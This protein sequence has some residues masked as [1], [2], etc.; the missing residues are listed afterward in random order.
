MLSDVKTSPTKGKS[1]EDGRWQSNWWDFHPLVEHIQRP[2]AWTTSS[3]IFVAHFTQPL[4][5]ARLL[6]SSKQF[7]IPSPAPVHSTPA[8]Y[9]PPTVISVSPNDHWLFAYFP[10]RE[11][12]GIGC[13]WNRGF[14]I[15]SW[16]VKEFWTF[17]RGA[18]V[19]AAAWA[20]AEREWVTS[21]DGSTSRL[22]HCGPLTPVTNPTLLLVT[23]AHQLNVC[24]LRTY[25]PSLRVMTC[26]L[27]QPYF[28]SE[29][30]AHPAQEMPGGA[31][32][33]R[34]CIR[35][36]IGFIYSE[37][38]ILIAMRSQRYPS[39]AMKHALDN[40]LEPVVPQG[41]SQSPTS[42]DDSPASIDWDAWGE[43]STIDLCEVKLRFDGM[44]MSLISNPLPP[45]HHTQAKLTNLLFVCTPF[46][47]DPTSS[48]RKDKQ[49]P[50][51][52]PPEL[53]STYL[54]ATFLDFEDYS[55][56]PKSEMTVFTLARNLP[57]TP[58]KPAWLARQI[59][60][61]SFSPR[62][63]TFS[64]PCV[65][66][67][68]SRKACV[69]A[70]L[71]DTVGIVP[72]NA[73]DRKEVPVGNL[74]VL[75]LSDLSTDPDWEDSVIMS[76]VESAGTHWPLSISVSPNRALV[77]A[78]SAVRTTIHVL[79]RIR[80]A[81][82]TKDLI[83]QRSPFA[84]PLVSA[85]LSRKS[86]ADISHVLSLRSSS[87]DL[88]VDTLRGAILLLEANARSYSSIASRMPEALGAVVEIYRTKAR[89]TE[90]EDD[91]R[92]FTALWQ[93]AHDMCSIAAYMRAFEECRDDDGY[94]LD[95]VWQLVSLSGWVISFLENLLK[96]CVALIDITD[97][98][99]KPKTE[100]VDVDVFSRDMTSSRA[101]F[102]PSFDTPILLHL[103]HPFASSNLCDVVS[104]VNRFHKFLGSL[105][106]KGE[107][108]HIARDVL[109]DLV[110]CSGLNVGALESA[111]K[112]TITELK[113][114][115]S[116][117]V[118]VAL[119]RCHPVPSM[120][121]PLRKIVQTLTSS[122]IV[123]KPRLF[124]KPS[125]LIDGFAS[126]STSEQSGKK[127]EKDVI[128]RG[129]LLKRGPGLSCVRCGSRS[130]IGS[131]IGVAGHISIKW[132]SWE[133]KWSAHCI[134]GG[135]WVSRNT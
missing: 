10:G 103:V 79:P 58:G 83:L 111:L 3:V 27:T 70:A 126:L 95:A 60:N 85:L 53:A 107:S 2:V 64:V 110:S 108:S 62:V 44:I 21:P 128:T 30:P 36:S 96:E 124:I 43:E 101:S 39:D 86:I 65:A 29:N 109:L 57:P 5:V 121:A 47:S 48:P 67:S 14:H 133:R 18:G 88:L 123:D 63:L 26:S 11:T 40:S 24:Y 112:G 113:H 122:S 25:S 68:I 66:P 32:T 81:I 59:A 132:R 84:L 37:S 98:E 92:H 119:A 41:A 131:E 114:I 8:S 15:D 74:V 33:S 94:D 125:D 9:E 51:N 82:D 46:R 135:S 102:L 130:E 76:P 4:V 34:Q 28:A 80:V 129:L 71:V 89:Q 16:S 22:P 56:P 115:P 38:S 54:V 116:D 35:A 19:V 93:N 134:C 127:Q 12:D 106:A 73:R 105:T 20:G 69:I 13:L 118:R 120:Y 100:P 23:Q 31:K 72:R 6:P 87:T 49:A 61:R 50:R 91:Q 52:H 7:S 42:T 1:K 90:D 97:T 17:P 104:H 45:L 55:A 78:V 75:Q 117:D 77:C 99:P